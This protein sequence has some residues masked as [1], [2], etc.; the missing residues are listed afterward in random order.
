PVSNATVVINGKAAQS[1]GTGSFALALAGETN[2]YVL[3]ITATGFELLSKVLPGGVVGG[4]YRLHKAQRFVVDPFARIQVT[5][6]KTNQLGAQLTIEPNS[7]VDPDGNL[8]AG[9]LNL[10]LSTLDMSDPAGRLPG[11][12]G[13]V[14]VG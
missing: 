10:F 14:N 1:N 13:A 2:R 3:T 8:A 7:L 5:Q 11:D 9:P 12:F 6:E 4:K